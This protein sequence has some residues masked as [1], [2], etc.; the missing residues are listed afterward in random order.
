LSFYHVKVGEEL[1]T[2]RAFFLSVKKKKEMWPSTT[3]KYTLTTNI[4]EEEKKGGGCWRSYK[5]SI[6]ASF[7][8][9]V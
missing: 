8:S 1:N 7:P 3:W 4:G 9:Y 2:L 5:K 6:N